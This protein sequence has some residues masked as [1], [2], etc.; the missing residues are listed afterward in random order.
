MASLAWS[1]PSACCLILS[2][3]STAR[4]RSRLN[5]GQIRARG[6]GQAAAAGEPPDLGVQRVAPGPVVELVQ[7]GAEQ[8]DQ[9]AERIPR[10]Q[11]D[12]CHLFSN[13]VTDDQQRTPAAASGREICGGETFGG[14]N[15]GAAA[16]LKSRAGS[17]PYLPPTLAGIDVF[18]SSRRAARCRFRGGT[19]CVVIPNGER[20]CRAAQSCC[21]V[22]DESIILMGEPA[23]AAV[24]YELNTVVGYLN[25]ALT[26]ARKG[27]RAIWTCSTHSMS[28]RPCE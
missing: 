20:Q 12:R 5:T 25:G 1:G 28:A 11:E 6:P 22:L 7:P 13:A 8:E 23:R 18:R 26:L 15:A 2:A 17:P 16:P 27:L 10:E 4:L 3:R 19:T 21:R 14:P 9:V 24:A